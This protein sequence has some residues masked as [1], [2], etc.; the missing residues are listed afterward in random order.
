[1]YNIHVSK[2]ACLFFVLIIYYAISAEDHR[3]T[4]PVSLGTTNEEGL[5]KLALKNQGVVFENDIL[6]IGVKVSFSR[7]L[8]RCS[9]N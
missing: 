8:L 9:F 1:M 2:F 7:A 5:A 4:P 6:Q 3:T